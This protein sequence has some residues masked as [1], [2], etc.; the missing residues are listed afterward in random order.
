MDYSFKQ[1]DEAYPR[2]EPNARELYVIEYI[3]ALDYQLMKGDAC[4][5]ERLKLV[6][7]AWRQYRM[8]CAAMAKALSA[9]YKT[10]PPKH[11][12][13]IVN[14]CSRGEVTVRMRGATPVDD[15][16]SVP[17]Q[18]LRLLINKVIENE[19]AMCVKDQRAQRRC[20]LRRALML[21]APPQEVKK[22]GCNYLAVVAGNDLGDYI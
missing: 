4:L 21:I 12:Q 18:E 11:L 6:P 16:Q 13:H 17:V 22:D 2:V 7:D 5:E 19:C 14:L 20:K 15:V 3:A 8:A 9:I 10:L 1:P